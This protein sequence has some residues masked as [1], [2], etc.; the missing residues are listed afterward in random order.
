MDYTIYK[1]GKFTWIQAALKSCINFKLTGSIF[2]SQN[3]LIFVLTL[4]IYSY[5]FVA[6]NMYSN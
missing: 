5:F 2:N 4:L 3:T 1:M 6:F